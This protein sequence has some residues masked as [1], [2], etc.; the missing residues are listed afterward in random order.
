MEDYYSDMKEDLE[1]D[2]ENGFKKKKNDSTH[3]LMLGKTRPVYAEKTFE[4]YLAN[5]T[6]ALL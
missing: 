6:K 4:D 3:A 5:Q 2:L 1:V